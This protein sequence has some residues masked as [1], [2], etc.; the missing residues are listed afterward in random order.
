[1]AQRAF[2]AFASDAA[3]GRARVAFEGGRLFKQSLAGD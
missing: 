1:M 2:F 3:T